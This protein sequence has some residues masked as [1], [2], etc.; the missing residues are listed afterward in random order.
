MSAR[1]ISLWSDAIGASGTVVVHGHWGRPVLAFPAERGGPWEFQDRGMVEAVSGL[2][3]AGR[4]KLYCVDSFD[5]ASWSNTSIPLEARAQEH[6]R[7]E[8]WIVDQRGAVDP[9]GL[10]RRAGHRH[11]RREPRRV[12]RRELRAQAG[13][14]V[15][16]RDRPLRQLRPG[17]LGRVGGT[18]HG[19]VLQQPDG[20]PAPTRTATT[21]SGCAG[22]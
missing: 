12:S 3:E 15:P 2:L 18:R 13:R 19:D 6:G 1:E 14:P 4:C 5:S 22:R 8:A 10:R 7:Y 11:G 16:D 17:E 21:S 20:L 9:R